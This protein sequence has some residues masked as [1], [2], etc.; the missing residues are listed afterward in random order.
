MCGI[1][2]SSN[3]RSGV[4]RETI[5]STWV[6]FWVSPD[7][8]EA[9]VG[10]ECPADAVQHQPV[11]ICND[12]THR[13]QSSIRRALFLRRVPERLWF[14]GGAGARRARRCH[15]DGRVAP[16]DGVESPR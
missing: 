4:V 9:A 5:G 7:D 13:I 16:C 8:L 15:A 10:L 6:P 3:T 14:A 11:I 2:T 1:R 12:D